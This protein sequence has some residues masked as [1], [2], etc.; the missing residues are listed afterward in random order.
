MG[1]NITVF[2]VN[3]KWENF[4][5]TFNKDREFIGVFN[6]KDNT[7]YECYD[8]IKWI[9]WL[10]SY[11]LIMSSSKENHKLLNKEIRKRVQGKL[12]KNLIF[13]T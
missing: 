7:L 1:K 9:R 3:I 12:E 2:T 8:L 10:Y 4:N 6:M 13:N 11:C 5:F